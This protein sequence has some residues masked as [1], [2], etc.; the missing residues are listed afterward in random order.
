MTVAA[1]AVGG[2]LGSLARY[3]L[4]RA[5]YSA[6]GTAFPYGTLIVNLLGC[7]L[8]GVIIGLVEEWG[9]LGPEARS[10]LTVGFLSAMTTFSTFVYES[11]GLLRDGAYL[12][13]LGYL[14]ASL[15]GGLVAFVLGRVLG[16]IGS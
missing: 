8:L 9:L 11:Y 1:V 5:L 14:M 13:C 16:S 10:L 3:F 2:A 4:A 12:L 6:L 7:F 15:W